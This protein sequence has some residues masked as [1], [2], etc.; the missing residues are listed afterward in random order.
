MEEKMTPPRFLLILTRVVFGLFV[1]WEGVQR[2]ITDTWSAGP[3]LL[4]ASFAPTIFAWFADPARIELVSK[5]NIWGLIIVGIALIIGFR[6]RF[7]S[8][9]G[10][11]LMIAYYFLNFDLSTLGT[12]HILVDHHILYILLFIILNNMNAGKYWGLDRGFVVKLRG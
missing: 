6:L 1:L 9:I 11:I 7:F 10:I 8:L 4:E 5:L 3:A 12:T 2:L